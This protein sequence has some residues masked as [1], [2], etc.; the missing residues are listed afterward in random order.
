MSET[1]TSFLGTYQ[2][3]KC[4]LSPV[5]TNVRNVPHF[6]GYLPEFQVSTIFRVH[7][8]CPKRLPVSW[9]PT[10]VRSVYSLGYIRMFET[11][12]ISLGTYQSSKCPLFF[13]YITSVRNVYQY[14]GYLPLFEVSTFTDTY[15]CSKRSPVWILKNIR[16][17]Y[18]FRR[19]VQMFGVSIIFLGIADF[20]C[21]AHH[22]FEYIRMFETSTSFLGTCKCSECPSFSWVR[23]IFFKCAHL[24]FE[25]IRIFVT[26]TSFLGTY[27]CSNCPIS[28]LR[29][30]VPPFPRWVHNPVQNLKWYLRP[31]HLQNLT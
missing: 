13:G 17:V 2:C 23:P 4:L 9:V 7:N 16:N 27:K 5:H 12:P 26:S 6:L 1:S 19:Y 18:Q 25:Y 29:T 28:W 22:L 21:S 30:N 10:N 11:S 20:L 14:L 24:L 15:E 31:P 3:S 8:E